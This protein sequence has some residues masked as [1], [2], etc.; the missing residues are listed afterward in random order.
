MTHN[1]L[2][3]EDSAISAVDIRALLTVSG[4][5]ICYG[6]ALQQFGFLLATA[7]IAAIAIGPVLGDWRWRSILGAS[8]LLSL[9]VYF[10]LGK[11]L[12]VYLPVGK[13]LNL[14]F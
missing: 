6:L 5:L 4:L 7:G 11:L 14:S 1:D 3:E 8:A 10:V 2:P 12:S 13:L 9:G